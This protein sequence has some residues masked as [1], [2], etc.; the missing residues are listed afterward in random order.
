MA[1]VAAALQRFQRLLEGLGHVAVIHHSAPQVDD[2]VDVFDQQGAFRLARAAR[3]ARPDFILGID[4]AYQSRAVARAAQHRVMREGVIARFDLYAERLHLIELGFWNSPAHW[5]H[6]SPVEL[7]KENAEHRSLHV[8]LDSE[9]AVAKQ[10]EKGQVMQKIGAQVE[11]R[12]HGQGRGGESA[13]QDPRRGQHGQEFGLL[14]LLR[15]GGS[16]ARL[17]QAVGRHQNGDQRQQKDGVRLVGLAVPRRHFVSRGFEGQPAHRRDHHAEKDNGCGAGLGNAVDMAGCAT[18]ERRGI[19]GGA[20][21]EHV[22]RAHDQ[23][24]K[25]R[26]KKNVKLFACCSIGVLSGGD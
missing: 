16:L 13:F 9:G 15:K 11:I 12:K 2:L 8:E 20:Q 14:A 10:K 5:L 19:A 18:E 6:G 22:K 1:G 25:A 26:I 21:A 3:G 7:R 24:N 23:H 17:E 4:A